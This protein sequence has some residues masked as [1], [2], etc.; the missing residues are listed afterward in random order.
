[1]R[2]E[3][4][5]EAV[6]LIDDE[7]VEEAARAPARRRPLREGLYAA[8][9][10]VLCLGLLRLALPLRFGEGAASGGAAAGGDTATASEGLSSGGTA[11]ADS[12]AD[13]ALPLGTIWGGGGTWLLTGERADLPEGGDAPQA[14]LEGRESWEGDPQA[15]PEGWYTDVEEYVGRSVCLAPDGRVYVALPGGGWAVAEA[16]QPRGSEGAAPDQGG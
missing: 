14:T 10:V 7:L 5:L 4:L 8:A 15:A 6:G 9:A 12:S 16:G 1:M 11:P 2:E 3:L 13:Q